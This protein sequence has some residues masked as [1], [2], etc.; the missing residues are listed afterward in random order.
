MTAKSSTTE[1][2]Y[3]WCKVCDDT[4]PGALPDRVAAIWL[5]CSEI[6]CHFTKP[7]GRILDEM[8]NIVSRS[9]GD[10]ADDADVRETYD[11]S[12]TFSNLVLVKQFGS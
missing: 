1:T 10:D 7:I 6:E 4:Q 3:R 11:T 8:V 9:S 12:L 2:G 5:Q